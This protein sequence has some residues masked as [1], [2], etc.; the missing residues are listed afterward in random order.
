MDAPRVSA[1]GIVLA[2]GEGT[3]LAPLTRHIVGHDC[4]KQFCPLVG[5]RTLL[6]QTL[7]R[8]APLISA[9]R[10]VVVGHR[11]HA[12]FPRRELR[13]P[14]PHV[15]LQ[16]SH[17]GTGAATLWPAHWVRRREPDGIVAVFPSDH[18]VRPERAFLAHVAR[19]VEVVRERPEL[20]V[21]LGMTPDGPEDGYGWIEPGEAVPAAPGCFHVRGFWEK[22]SADRAHAFFRSGFLW[23]SLVVVARAR[24]LCAL[25]RAYLPDVDAELAAIPAG[26]DGEDGARAAGRA[27][28][29]MR[30]A[31]FS[32]DV[33]E[34]GGE[35]L[36]VLPVQGV[37]W[38]DWGTPERVVRTFRRIGVAPAW[39]AG[40]LARSA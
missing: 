17:R 26:A 3:R 37:L 29:R 20:I 31:N 8:I 2:G 10:T 22:P 13:G 7:A 40:W 19:A 35:A 15:L 25:G 6:G 23:N 5:A 38:S 39:L 14:V 32:R 28:A 4:P 11:A 33:L 21:L 12:G 34:P 24:A 27:Y 18:F 30:P 16:P 1:W 36:A 9:E